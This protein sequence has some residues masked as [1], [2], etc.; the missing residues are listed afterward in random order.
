MRDL[1]ILNINKLK[2]AQDI[3]YATLEA[4]INKVCDLGYVYDPYELKFWNP[5]I[6]K[7]IY[8]ND[9]LEDFNENFEKNLKERSQLLINGKSEN[10]MANIRK[11]ITQKN[12]KFFSFFF[13]LFPLGII[14]MISSIFSFYYSSIEITILLSI[15][16]NIC[17]IFFTAKYVFKSEIENS[18]TGLPLAWLKFSFIF[19]ILSF[20]DFVLF[21]L[22]ISKYF[23]NY[24]LPFIVIY[25][26]YLI[27]PQ[28]IIK[29]LSQEYWYFSG[30]FSIEEFADEN[31]IT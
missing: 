30:I 4:R 3:P 13:K 26:L 9:I 28:I 8:S 6:N 27:V 11:I 2:R 18:F 25:V 29:H 31:G 1:A 12:N 21:Y 24:W 22:F 17:V 15:L 5:F 7:F 19:I 16:S 10:N 20:I 14:F 23:D